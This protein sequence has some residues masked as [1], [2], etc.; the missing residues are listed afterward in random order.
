M[1]FHQTILTRSARLWAK[2]SRVLAKT[3]TNRN[4]R[5]DLSWLALHRTTNWLTE[6]QMRWEKTQ[7]TT[8]TAHR[9]DTCLNGNPI[10]ITEFFSGQIRRSP[11]LK[12]LVYVRKKINS[13]NSGLVFLGWFHAATTCC[14]KLDP[15][16]LSVY[17]QRFARSRCWVNIA[18]RTG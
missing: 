8:W 2:D 9:Q 11:T 7:T 13:I 5:N 3:T 1:W 15:K 4:N 16:R 14:S 18:V 12:T 17:F 6:T 10:V